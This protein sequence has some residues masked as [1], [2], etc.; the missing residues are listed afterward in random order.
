MH[1]KGKNTLAFGQSPFSN[2]HHLGRAWVA[3]QPRSAGDARGFAAVA[4]PELCWDMGDP[5]G[6]VVQWGLR[7]E[8]SSPV[9]STR[10]NPGFI[11]HFVVQ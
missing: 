5:T 11:S 4:L 6:A 3:F 9:K 10:S 8:H 7:E 1:N 2:Q